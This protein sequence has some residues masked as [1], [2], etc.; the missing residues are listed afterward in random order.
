MA[1]RAIGGGG[2]ASPELLPMHSQGEIARLG[3][4]A[5]ATHRFRDIRRV[6]VLLVLRVALRTPDRGV[7]RGLQLLGGIVTF[8]AI[9]G[10][11]LDRLESP[12]TLSKCQLLLIE[13]GGAAD[14][15]AS[16]FR[17]DV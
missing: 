9:G 14:V 11:R 7:S 5:V 17:A 6:R 13:P 15:M 3:S 10:R 2:V 1:N 4:V 12:I 8:R 16:F